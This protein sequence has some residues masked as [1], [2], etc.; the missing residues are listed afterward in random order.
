MK[1]LHEKILESTVRM[2]WSNGFLNYGFW[3]N[4]HIVPI[5]RYINYTNIDRIREIIN[6]ILSE[7]DSIH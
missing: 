1:I 3:Y 2:S 6:E 7:E 5:N 4:C